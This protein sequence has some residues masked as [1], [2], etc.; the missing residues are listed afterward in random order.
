MLHC[1]QPG[2]YLEYGISWQIDKVRNSCDGGKADAALQS[3]CVSSGSGR[4][5]SA[6]VR[7]KRQSTERAVH[8][9]CEYITQHPPRYCRS[10]ITLHQT[11]QPTGLDS[12]VARTVTGY[13]EMKT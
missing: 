13:A 1:I 12:R 10:S 3:A 4:T 7:L 11:A 2:E 9:A 8:I 5:K 6:T